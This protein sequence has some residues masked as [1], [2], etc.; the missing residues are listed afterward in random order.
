MRADNRGM[1]SIVGL[2]MVVLLLVMFAWMSPI[3]KN[4]IA[5]AKNY[6]TDSLA[7]MLLDMIPFI[8]LVGILVSW[9]IYSGTR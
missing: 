3:V 5:Y 6:V 2:V 1:A 9:I 8:L 7:L 4:A